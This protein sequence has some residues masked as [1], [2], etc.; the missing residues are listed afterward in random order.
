M[1]ISTQRRIF[2][3]LYSLTNSSQIQQRPSEVS[4]DFYLPVSQL[5]KYCFLGFLLKIFYVKGFISFLESS[6]HFF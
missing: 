5:K 2:P 1:N 6:L 4:R 3:H